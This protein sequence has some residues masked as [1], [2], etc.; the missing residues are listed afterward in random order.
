VSLAVE[1]AAEGLAAGEMPIGAVVV[2]G[3]QILGR[4][5]TQERVLGRRLVHA[6]LLA[7]SQADATL[8]FERMGSR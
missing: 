5:F 6:D 7:L 8:G 4:A 3:D 2:S 1:T